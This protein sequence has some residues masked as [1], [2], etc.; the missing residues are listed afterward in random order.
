MPLISENSIQ[1]VQDSSD[2]VDI[3]E[4]YGVK[5]KRTGSSFLAVCPFHNE[6]T[7]SFNV[8][9]QLQIFKCF[10]CGVGGS[11]IKFVQLMERCEFPEAIEKLATRAGVT[12]EYENGRVA[13]PAQAGVNKDKKQALLW[14]CKQAFDYFRA[15]LAD[16][17]EGAAAREYLLSRGFKK[18][19]ITGWGLGWAPERWEGLLNS[20]LKRVVALS[21]D[22]KVEQ[23]KEIGLEAGIFRQKDQ[24]DKVYDAFRGRVMFPI[25]DLQERPIGFGGRVLEEKPESGGKY[26]NTS[27]TPL[28][29]KRNL[30]FGLNFAAKEI[31]LTKTAIVVEGYTDTIMC[32]QY[33]IR[34]VVATLGT[35]L[36]VEHIRLLKRYIHNDGKVLALFDNDSAGKKATMR[37]IDLFMEEDV[38]LWVLSS[39]EVKDAGEFL[40]KFGADRFKEFI[41]GAKESFAYVIEEELGS[42]D[43][44]GDL[45]GKTAAIESIM[46]LVNLCPNLLRRN[47]M[48]SKV[49]EVAGVSENSLPE[50]KENRRTRYQDSSASDFQ[51]FSRDKGSGSKPKQYASP[52]IIDAQKQGKLRAEDRLLRYMFL[53]RQWCDK[54]V[55][56]YP[57]DEWYGE[58]EHLCATLIRD[59]WFGSN[60]KRIR[61]ERLL[62]KTVNEGVKGLLLNFVDFA[63]SSDKDKHGVKS[64]GEDESLNAAELDDILSRIRI[65]GLKDRRDGLSAEH[66]RAELSGNKELADTLLL[67]KMK[68][69]KEI[70]GL[71]IS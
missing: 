32:H 33:G 28:F 14:A 68:I 71:N 37:A 47:M 13:D 61:V 21:G 57:P 34:N 53:D 4:S 46:D 2:I 60:E 39:L 64:V 11:A 10:G 52:I 67:E 7:P 20:Y 44:S 15:A 58:V 43:F 49:A 19:T 22:H 18:E 51:K 55:D 63:Y 35:S 24:S 31:G 5:L 65:D 8:N 25:F 30:L 3:V 45:G 29:M 40:P 59:E 36:T 27:E 54:I 41:A 12:L 23:A 26:I 6:K 42:K 69:E 56:E 70:R 16:D 9:P 50:P 48:R 62:E 1:R 38:N 66:A 17:R